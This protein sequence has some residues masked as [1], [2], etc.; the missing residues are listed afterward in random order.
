M[1][2]NS[3][4]HGTLAERLG[5]Q[6]SNVVR[7]MHPE[8]F[9]LAATDFDLY[10]DDEPTAMVILSFEDDVTNTNSPTGISEESWPSVSWPQLSLISAIIVLD[11][12][13]SDMGA[14]QPGS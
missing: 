7:E 14:N 1:A 8:A 12:S 6:S 2:A 9:I 5:G 4:A 13:E 11:K 3:T 10:L